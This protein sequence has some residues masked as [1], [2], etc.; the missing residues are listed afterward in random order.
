MSAKDDL[1]YAVMHANTERK[2]DFT[3][4]EYR[5]ELKENAAKEPSAGGSGGAACA[6]GDI[7]ETTTTNA[8]TWDGVIG[9][10]FMVDFGNGCF[11]HVSDFV[12]GI[13]VL[14]GDNFDGS[15]VMSGVSMHLE[16]GFAEHG[17]FGDGIYVS[18]QEGM[19][20]ALIVERD[21][22]EI[23][24]DSETT[25]SLK[26]GVY[27]G[28][29]ESGG[30]VMY[31]ESISHPL[32]AVPCV[33]VKPEALPDNIAGPC[34]LYIGS[35]EGDG[36]TRVYKTAE[37]TAD[38]RMSKAELYSMLQSGRAMWHVIEVGGIEMYVHIPS[39]TFE[40]GK[41]YAEVMYD[42]K[43]TSAYTAEYTG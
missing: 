16:M 10:R 43:G 22:I 27:F 8:I 31:V 13:D 36:I 24:I 30:D 38:V 34:K 37:R 42:T 6:C 4:E 18:A 33:K 1:L 29:M 39:I 21:G 14:S 25:V 20:L 9:D 28:F 7:T 23:P 5:D 41:D 26:A 12:P 17:G 11:V 40:S 3:G 35:T 15:A 32:L 19:M 2:G